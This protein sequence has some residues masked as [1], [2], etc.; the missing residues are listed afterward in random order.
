MGGG[1]L[2][3]PPISLGLRTFNAYGVL[4]N[5]LFLP[6]V[7]MTGTLLSLH[8]SPTIFANI[9]II[10]RRVRRAICTVANA[11]E[12]LVVSVG[13]RYLSRLIALSSRSEAR[14]IKTHTKPIIPLCFTQ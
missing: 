2:Q 4:K 10:L 1:L 9:K 13:R 11:I 6:A 12:M 3:H 7:E 8:L 5:I 14:D